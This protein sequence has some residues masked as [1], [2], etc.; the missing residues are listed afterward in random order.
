MTKKFTQIIAAYVPSPSSRNALKHARDLAQRHKSNLTV[1]NVNPDKSPAGQVEREV[2]EIMK[3]SNVHFI[4]LEKTGKPY[5]EVLALEKELEA[6]L[7]VMGTHGSKDNDPDWIGG[8]AFKV[9]SGSRC[10]VITFTPGHKSDGFKNIVLPIADSSETRQKVPLTIAIAKA[11]NAKI[12]IAIVNKN[13]DKEVVNT[14]KIYASQVEGYCTDHGVEFT[15][16][17]IYNKNIA[18]ACIDY[19]NEIGADLISIMSERES[20]TGF[21]MGH[22]AQQLVNKAHISVLTMHV[23]DTRIAGGGGY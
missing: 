14:L 8:N 3:D 5:K 13:E 6:D 10:P 15:L 2:D 21:F 23:R 18:D 22:Y 9:L 16:K 4:I 1:L 7:I 12:H 20:P 17:E 11:Y 19:A